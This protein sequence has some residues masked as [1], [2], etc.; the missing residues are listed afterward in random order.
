MNYETISLQDY[1]NQYT[2]DYCY[3]DETANT[4]VLLLVE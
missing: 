2:K 1:F 4:I 3:F